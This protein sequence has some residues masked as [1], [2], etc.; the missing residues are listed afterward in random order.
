MP[1]HPLPRCLLYGEL[2]QKYFIDRHVKATLKK[3][4]M[5]ASDLE[6]LA[7]D[8]D[9]CSSTC[10][11]DLYSFSCDLVA[12]TLP[13]RLDDNAGTSQQHRSPAVLRGGYLWQGLHIHISLC[14][15][16][17]KHC[18]S[19]TYSHSVLV[20]QLQ[21]I[22]PNYNLKSVCQLKSDECLG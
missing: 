9:D 11:S 2:L 6:P 21:A 15:Y 7:T 20:G 16:L 10:E 17:R 19:R 22:M 1:S 8:R 5:S 18:H 3:C 14:S 12:A 13:Q 4:Q